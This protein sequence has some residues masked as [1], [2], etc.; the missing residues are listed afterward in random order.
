MDRFFHDLKYA[1]RV[2]WRD[3]GFAA[4]VIFT[5]AVCIG[6]NAAIFAI[7]NGVLLR[8]LPIPE[9][10]RIVALYNSYPKAGVERASSGVPDYYDR[11]R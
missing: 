1:G 7:I 9:S 4:T 11:R 10:D 5:L 6:A 3:R 2:L 8:P